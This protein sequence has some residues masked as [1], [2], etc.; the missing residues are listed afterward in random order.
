MVLR[1]IPLSSFKPGALVKGAVMQQ[2]LIIA[3]LAITLIFASTGTYALHQQ[4]SGQSRDFAIIDQIHPEFARKIEIALYKDQDRATNA[5]RLLKLIQIWLSN[6]Q[7]PDITH[8]LDIVTLQDAETIVSCIE[9]ASDTLPPTS[10]KY[11]PIIIPEPELATPLILPFSGESTVVQGIRGKISHFPGSSNEYAWD[12]S[13]MKNGVLSHGNAGRNKN[14]FSWHQP[15]IAAA[16]GTVVKVVD[17]N[18]DH[19]PMTTKLND[20]NYVLIQHD[21]G[22]ISNYHHISKNTITVAAGQK[23]SAGD[24]IG[25]IGDSGISMFPHLH[26]QLEKHSGD[27]RITVQ[28][29]FACYFAKLPNEKS[30]RLAVNSIPVEHEYVINVSDYVALMTGTDM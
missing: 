18:E 25:L 9:K 15:I 21:T 10:S 20:A 26:F 11:I 8:F 13:I 7:Y 1:G 19:P 16:D 2:R 4:H 28:S 27:K 30:W 3:L 12:F 24:I 22:V 29:F 23:V 17:G 6:N 14:Y 5:A